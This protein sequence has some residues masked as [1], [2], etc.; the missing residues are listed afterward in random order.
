[1]SEPIV[2][3]HD[4]KVAYPLAKGYVLNEVSF[5][6]RR[7]EFVLVVGPTGSGKTT[8]LLA[9]AGAIPSLIPARVEGL[10]KVAGRFPA[11]EGLAGL[12]GTVGVVFQDPESQYVMPTVIEEVYFPG[13]NLA[14]SPDEVERR[15][16]RAL[17]LVGLEEYSDR[18]VETLSTGLKQRLAI[19]SALVLDPEVLL[20]DEPTAHI[21]M[22]TAREIYGILEELK[23]EGKTVI[24]VEHRVELAEELADKV[25][26]ISGDGTSRVYPSIRDLVKEI[27]AE[28]LVAEGVWIPPEYAP[29]ARGTQLAGAVGSRSDLD[30][31]VEGLT[32]RFGLITALSGMSLEVRRGELVAVLGPNGS[33][34]TTLL[35][36][37]AGLVRRYSGRVSVAGGPPHPSKVAFVA[38]V[39]ELQFTER[40]VVEE[41]ASA[42][43]SQGLREGEALRRARELLEARGLGELSDAIVYE[44]SQGEKRLVSFLEMELLERKV[45]L[46]DEPTFGLDMKYSALVAAEIENLV[47]RGKTVVLVT[48]DSWLLFLLNPRV[49][50]LSGGRV[51]FEGNLRELLAR[52][53][54]WGELAFLPPR[55]ALK[56][57]E[58]LGPEEAVSEYSARLGCLHESLGA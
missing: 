32:V 21:D 37:L 45:Y 23:R 47:K 15:A 38:Q 34:K 48:H 5:E 43:R 57:L 24:V 9:L 28:K 27:G 2:L 14:L 42:L 31:E 52:R 18:R 26:Y 56:L 25:V 53:N 19:A 7:G 29:C 30:V 3:V 16:R 17:E 44:L 49:Y 35:K 46:L 4:L 13:E 8:L 50:G 55:Y 6:A 1:M 41:L 22:R 33:G 36:V 10:V 40:T 51:V 12:A 39:P 20:L 54:L 58:E 11:E